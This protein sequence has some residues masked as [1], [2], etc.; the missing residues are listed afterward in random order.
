P[1]LLVINVSYGLGP[2]WSGIQSAGWSPKILTSALVW[3]D[4]FTGMGPLA[5]N[6]NTIYQNC[7]AEGHPPFPKT[8]T[9]EMDIY[10]NTFGT[11]SVNY[12]TFVSNDSVPLEM[13]KVAIEKYHS[14]DGD[15]IKKAMEE[16]NNQMFFGTFSF[17]YTP[18]NHRGI[19]GTLGAAVCKTTPFGDG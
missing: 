19:N 8:L 11:N 7:A 12:L 1:D 17:T 5:N 2:I 18:T 6:S 10:A 4:S 14:I 13:M 3:Y 16:M 9:D 15:A